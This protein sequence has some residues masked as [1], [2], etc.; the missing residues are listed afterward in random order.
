MESISILTGTKSTDRYGDVVID[1][2]APNSRS[3]TGCMVAPRANDHRED[4][5]GRSAVVDGWKVY[6][7]PGTA[8]DAHERVVV[9]G[10]VHDVYGAPE[11]WSETS[12]TPGGV[13]ISTRRVQG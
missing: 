7:P 1:W 8:L 5:A 4:N 6:A 3:V 9:R 2:S 11:E 10:E 13:V 12:M